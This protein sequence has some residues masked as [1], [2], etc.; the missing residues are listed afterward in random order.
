MVAFVIAPDDPEST[1]VRALLDAHLAFAKW[2]S[3][4]EDVHALEVDE[5]LGENV[6]FFTIRENGAL[7]GVGALKHLDDLHVEIKSMHTAAAAR[8]RGVGRAM[9]D[10]LVG[11]ARAR[12]YRRVSIET[13]STPVFAPARALYASAG[14]EPCGPFGDYQL[15]PNSAYMTLELDHAPQPAETNAL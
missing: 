3:P 10:H 7:V 15:S 13:G 11:I 8:R 2:E 9:V 1:D 6:S 12:G 5:L 4:P 14:F